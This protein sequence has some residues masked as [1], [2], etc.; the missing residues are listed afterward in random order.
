LGDDNTIAS[1]NNA[2]LPALARQFSAPALL[3]NG[4]TTLESGSAGDGT[5]LDVLEKAAG[6]R[7]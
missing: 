7:K 1:V 6:G 4:R 3:W 2:F 5:H